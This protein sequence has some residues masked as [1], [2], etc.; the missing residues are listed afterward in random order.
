[1]RTA[2][3]IEA[4]PNRPAATPEGDVSPVPAMQ[5]AAHQVLHVQEAVVA[6]MFRAG[7]AFLDRQRDAYG[8]AAEQ[9]RRLLT[10]IPGNAG[11]IMVALQVMHAQSLARLTAEMQAS[12]D[13]IRACR[14]CLD[15][16]PVDAPQ[17]PAPSVAA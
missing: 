1:M 14:T 5:D 11:L 10:A 6:E 17:A 3:K 2:Q 12:L 16:A 7:Q 4:A 13:L 8:V 9:Q 15:P